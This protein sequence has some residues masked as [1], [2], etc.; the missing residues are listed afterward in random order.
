ML[1]QGAAV[2]LPLVE[3]ELRFGKKQQFVCQFFRKFSSVP[4]ASF[5]WS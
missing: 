2:A 4:I 1:A 3:V 5:T